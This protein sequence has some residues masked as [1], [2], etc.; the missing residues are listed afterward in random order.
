MGKNA[1]SKDWK[2]ITI[3]W[4]DLQLYDDTETI[5][6]CLNQRQV[7]IL[8]ALLIPAYWETRWTQLTATKDELEKYIAEL[9]N[10]L[11][12]NDCE[13]FGMLDFRDNPLDQCE[14]QYSSDAGITWTTMF[15]KDVC[16]PDSP[17]STTT[18]TNLYVDIDTNN[19][20]VINYGDD[21][22][23][24]APGWEYV[25]PFSDNA[26]CWVL[27]KYV[28]WICDFAINEINTRNRE[29]RNENNWL[30]DIAVMVADIVIDIAIVSAGTLTLPGVIVGA[31]AWATVQAVEYFWDS[32]VNLSSDHFS[33]QDTRDKIHCWMFNKLRGDTPYFSP[34]STS[35]DNFDGDNADQDA[36]AAS[37]AT[38]NTTVDIF[39]EWMMLMNSVTAI[40]E[41]LDICDCPQVEIINQLA[42]P[43]PFTDMYGTELTSPT[44]V[45]ISDD[46]GTP[47]NC[48]GFYLSLIHI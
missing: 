23:N 40:A 13:V 11:D 19:T 16:A 36:V 41:T 10:Q 29:L 37:V 6:I 31:L 26:L 21:I 27:R 12:G 43:D 48:P 28:N 46:G 3:D 2:A 47:V 42:G 35:L 8:K 9:E 14:V 32:L 1:S 24:V 38:F 33:D 15:R 7:A 44:T 20:N 17:G 5:G 4:A 30:D 34:W 18:I 25:N 45:E 39:I 22:I